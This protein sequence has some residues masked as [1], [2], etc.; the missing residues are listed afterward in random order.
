MDEAKVVIIPS[1][2]EEMWGI[3]LPAPKKRSEDFNEKFDLNPGLGVACCAGDRNR[4][5]GVYE[6]LNPSDESLLVPPSRKTFSRM[7]PPKRPPHTPYF[8]LDRKH[9][10]DPTKTY[11]GAG[12]V[13]SNLLASTEEN[14]VRCDGDFDDSILHTDSDT[15]RRQILYL[16]HFVN[17]VPLSRYS[18]KCI[19]MF[20]GRWVD[21]HSSILVGQSCVWWGTPRYASGRLKVIPTTWSFWPR[22]PFPESEDPLLEVFLSLFCV[23][24]KTGSRQVLW[25]HGEYPFL[26]MVTLRSVRNPVR[27]MIPGT[28]GPTAKVDAKSG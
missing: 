28:P 10:T 15:N 23:E 13:L 9:L 14:N 26:P 25:A 1:S 18:P 22:E 2:V 17:R 27:Q 19:L 8:Y 5:E 16:G 4:V 24:D 21:C 7:D 12:V 11:L 6:G 20:A 3:T